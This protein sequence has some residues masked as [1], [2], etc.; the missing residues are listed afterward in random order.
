MPKTK[1][2]EPLLILVGAIL[3]IMWLINAMNTGNPWW[4]LPFQPSYQPS[5]IVVRDYGTAVT[6]TP[7]TP[8]YA[9]LTTAFDEAF[10]DFSNTA[11]IDLGLGDETLRRYAEEEL[12]IEIYYPE[13]ITFN[14]PVRMSKVNQLLIPVEA[15]HSGHGYLFLGSSGLW[16]IGP[17]VMANEQ[18]IID[19]MR[20]L[21]YLQD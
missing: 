11:L 14:T 3:L 13:Y 2:K 16:R 17:M 20:Q 1:V 10:S 21:G 6:I 18:P 7:G 8:E 19:A 12:V 9:T 15:T 5:R 4:F